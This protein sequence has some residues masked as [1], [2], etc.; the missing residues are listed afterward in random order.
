MQPGFWED[1]EYAQRTM[2]RL[3]TLREQVEPWRKLQKRVSDAQ[4]LAEI[5]LL[6]AQPDPDLVAELEAEAETVAQQYE[7]M[8][9]KVALSGE[10][11][12]G[13]ALLSVYAGAGGT[14]SQDWAEMLLRMYLRWA[15]QNGYKVEILD[16]MEGEQAG[17]KSVTMEIEG[18][19]AYGYL[20][21]E[22]GPHR[23]VRIS[24]F[25]A[26][27]RRHTSFAGVDVMPVL[28]DDVDIDI[29]PN[30]IEMEVYRAS[31]AGG[32]HVQKNSTAVRL[33]HK[34]SGIVVTCQNERSQ[35]Q[36]REQAMKV[37]KARLYERE[38]ERMDEERAKIA[39]THKTAEWGN[40]IRSYVLHPYQM[41][42]DHR[43]D[44]ETGNTQAVL[45]GDIEMFINAYLK[46]QLG[47][48]GNGS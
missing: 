29:D 12:A 9:F 47:G 31:G 8:E 13:S 34:P 39:G 23:L 21:S 4:E 45:D 2:R 41:V 26:N 33:V 17:I 24:P 3:S 6:E 30:D 46:N 14:E 28:D 18:S 32:Q 22:K 7:K 44:T 11:D 27:S 15:D 36:N 19:F 16:R 38:Q 10:H 25:D 43:T 40:Q 35:L 20:K 42:K 48:N 5:A 37:L 1:N